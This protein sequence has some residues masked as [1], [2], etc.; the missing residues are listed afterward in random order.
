M[1]TATNLALAV[2][3]AIACRD[4]AAQMFKCTDAAGKV[5]YSSTKCS[6]LKL[7]DAGEVPDRIQVTPAPGVQAP[8][9]R[10]GARSDR[11]E[12][13]P[14]PAATSEDPKPERRCF[15]TSVGGK[16]VTRCNDRPDG[17]AE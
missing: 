7:K 8:A 4:A 1:K 17:P 5:T 14:K 12:L 6:D 11:E 9:A 13:A 16:S 15:T 3:M 10:P 2:L